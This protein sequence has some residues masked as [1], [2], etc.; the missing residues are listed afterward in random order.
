M[1]SVYIL[2]ALVI[3]LAILFFPGKKKTQ[4]EKEVEKMMN[5]EK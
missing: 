1:N 3:A 4:R 5:I 2:I